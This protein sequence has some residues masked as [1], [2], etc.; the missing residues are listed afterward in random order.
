MAME[1]LHS[2]ERTSAEMVEMT[3]R[4]KCE[5][6]NCSQQGFTKTVNRYV[7]SAG[8]GLGY[9]APIICLGCGAEPRFLKS[10]EQT[11]AGD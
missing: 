11:D 7:G 1:E 4:V 9:K 2:G 6:P 8:P 5:T 3:V 10:Q